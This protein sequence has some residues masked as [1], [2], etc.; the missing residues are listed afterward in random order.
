FYKHNSMPR[1]SSNT[2]DMHLSER[3]WFAV[4]TGH[5]K[6]KVVESVLHSKQVEV[7]IPTRDRTAHYSSKV[8]TRRI[9]I[10]NGYVFVKVQQDEVAK[11]LNTT[12]VNG[13][14]K[15]GSQY[16]QVTEQE[17]QHLR[18]LSSDSNL[19]I[20]EISPEYVPEKGILMEIKRGP[21]AG[22]RGHFIA[23]KS[24]NLF[25]IAIGGVET[26]LAIFEIN[27]DNLLPLAG[28]RKVVRSL[29]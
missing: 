6:E 18:F 10:L 29:A 12:F 28:N 22:L 9:P 11:V 27:P 25:L 14:I 2:G 26:R 1:L 7:Y 4:R 15:I 17:M 8:V 23:Q 13:F 16:R 19:R 20:E 21:L 5:R 3:R 24:K